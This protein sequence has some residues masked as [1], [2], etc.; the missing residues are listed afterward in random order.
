MRYVHFCSQGWKTQSK[1]ANEYIKLS[2]QKAGLK[3]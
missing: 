1:G 2:I 3:Y